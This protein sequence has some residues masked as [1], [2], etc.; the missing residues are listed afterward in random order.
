M[1]A[2]TTLPIIAP[3]PMNAAKSAAR[4][5]EY[6]RNKEDKKHAV[7]LVLADFCRQTDASASS[8]NDDVYDEDDVAIF[9]S[10]I[11]GSRGSN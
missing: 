3:R 7:H 2:P 8:V 11:V 5:L 1:T 6:Y 10:A 9:L 4:H